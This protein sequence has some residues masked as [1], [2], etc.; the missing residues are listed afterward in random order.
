MKNPEQ[1]GP[2]TD[3]FNFYED[4]GAVDLVAFA[5]AWASLPAEVARVIGEYAEDECSLLPQEQN[6]TPLDLDEPARLDAIARVG[7]WS[8]EIDA[9][10]GYAPQAQLP[11]IAE[12]NGRIVPR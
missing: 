2:G 10:L 3:S 1:A 9:V 11:A 4:V 6:G 12:S 5:E 8:A 7:G